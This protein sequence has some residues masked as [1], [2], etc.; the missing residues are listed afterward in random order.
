MTSAPSVTIDQSVLLILILGLFALIGLRRGANRELVTVVGLVI[1]YLLVTLTLD[2][3]VPWVNKLYRLARFALA[4]GL[5]A[6]DPVTAWSQ[7]QSLPLLVSTDVARRNLGLACF[8]V[9]ATI[10][11]YVGSRTAPQGVS[12]IARLVGLLLGAVNGFVVASYLFRHALVSASATIEV[13]SG[14]VRATVTSSQTVGKIV[15]VL[16]VALIAFGLHGASGGRPS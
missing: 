14:A 2:S 13:A 9:L 7:V 4:G 8:A 11:Y 10:S 3:L 5:T 12:A 15:V 6:D 1:S 16:V